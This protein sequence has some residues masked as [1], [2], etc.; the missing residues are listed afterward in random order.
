MI[1]SLNGNE[2][3]LKIL[4]IDDNEADAELLL[5]S[6]RGKKTSHVYCKSPE[7]AMKFFRE[8]PFDIIVSDYNIPGTSGLEIYR[9]IRELDPE[10]PFIIASGA[11]GEEFAV[12]LLREGITDYVLKDTPEKLPLALDRAML[13]YRNKQDIKKTVE[14][15]LVINRLNTQIIETSDQVFYVCRVAEEDLSRISLGYISPQVEEIFRLPKSELLADINLWLDLIHE[16]DAHLIKDRMRTFIETKEPS[17]ISYRLKNEAEGNYFWIEDYACPMVNANGRIYELYGSARNVTDKTLALQTLQVEKKQRALYQSQL[18]SSQLNP[19]FIYNTLNSFQYYILSG[20]V[21]ESLNN[22]SAFSALMRQVLENSIYKTI[23]FQEEIDFIYRYI[24][25]SKRRLQQPFECS[26]VTSSNFD[27]AGQHIPPMLLQPYIENAFVHG[28]SSSPVPCLLTIDIKLEDEL[29]SCCI[30]DNG[31]GRINAQAARV[32]KTDGK[33][34]LGMGINE[35]RIRL[36]NETSDNNFIVEVIDLFDSN[37]K[38]AG[39]MVKVQFRQITEES[40]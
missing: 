23:S 7:T 34:S 30:T 38:S 3:H 10:I 22:I 20:E 13:E 36:L 4:L 6:L 28:F 9:Q 27:P 14:Q 5:R 19:H 15:L 39:T 18:L 25:I 11:L 29:V 8:Q 35:S 40:E 2:E 33:N 32:R 1:T 17:K 24:E 21:E 37:K 31:I 12:D 16:E 26:I